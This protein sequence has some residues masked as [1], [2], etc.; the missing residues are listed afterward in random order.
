MC[1]TIKGEKKLCRGWMHE[2]FIGGGE[3]EIYPFQP[4]GI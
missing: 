4:G 1:Y 2:I 3:R